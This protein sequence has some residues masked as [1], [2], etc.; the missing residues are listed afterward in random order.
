MLRKQVDKVTGGEGGKAAFWVT[1]FYWARFDGQ[2]PIPPCVVHEAGELCEPFAKYLSSDWLVHAVCMLHPLAT[3]TE[4]GG[5]R[6]LSTSNCI[7]VPSA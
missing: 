1:F 4:T 7:V 5:S 2:F 3:W 6:S